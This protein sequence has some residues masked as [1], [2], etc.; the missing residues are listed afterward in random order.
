MQRALADL[1]GMKR[2]DAARGPPVVANPE[3]WHMH[4]VL[5]SESVAWVELGIF[6]VAPGPT[7]PDPTRP[8]PTRPDSI[9]FDP[10]YVPSYAETDIDN[11]ELMDGTPD[12]PGVHRIPGDVDDDTRGAR[13]RRMAPPRSQG[14]RH[15]PGAAGSAA[16]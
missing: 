9:R 6:D 16:R 12:V 13:K 8:D 10:I 14:S 3:N 11:H 4:E 1:D 15:R 5:L 7:R 2:L